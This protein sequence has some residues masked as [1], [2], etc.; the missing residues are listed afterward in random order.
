MCPLE[1]VVEGSCCGAFRRRE[2]ER[3][4]GWFL[5]GISL[6]YREVEN[7]GRVCK[8][9]RTS[10]RPRGFLGRVWG[11][12]LHRKGKNSE[13][14]MQCRHMGRPGLTRESGN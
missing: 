12:D 6:E 2:V 8:R 3:T 11:V 9:Y 7:R 5:Q 4:E 10:R 13:D 1:D 14:P